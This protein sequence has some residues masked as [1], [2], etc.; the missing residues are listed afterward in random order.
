[1]VNKDRD[2]KNQI[3][4]IEKGTQLS[5]PRLTVTGFGNLGIIAMLDNRIDAMI[6]NHIGVT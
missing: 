5:A 3:L 4:T 1:M 2:G 6:C